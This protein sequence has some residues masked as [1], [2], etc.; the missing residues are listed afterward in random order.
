MPTFASNALQA[1][2]RQKNL[3]NVLICDLFKKKKP[4]SNIVHYLY[5]IEINQSANKKKRR[6]CSF[7]S[8]ILVGCCPRQP[9]EAS[10]KRIHFPDVADK[11]P[12]DFP[13]FLYRGNY[14]TLMKTILITQQYRFAQRVACYN[15]RLFFSKEV[16]MKLHGL[17]QIDQSIN[18]F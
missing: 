15:I 17:P 16:N 1:A 7:S 6:C 12:R 5:Q 18:S 8:F 13:F 2:I 14:N 4:K 11:F 9:A 3:R 10:N